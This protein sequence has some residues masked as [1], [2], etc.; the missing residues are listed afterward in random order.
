MRCR[1]SLRHRCSKASHTS[2]ISFH[3]HAASPFRLWHA[4]I[5]TT[6][7]N[8]YLTY[9]TCL[10]IRFALKV[11][12]RKGSTYLGRLIKY[13]PPINTTSTPRLHTRGSTSTSIACLQM[14]ESLLKLP[15][16]LHS[17]HQFQES[18]YITKLLR[19]LK[20][21]YG[22]TARAYRR[23]N[24]FLDVPNSSS[25]PPLLLVSASSPVLSG[26]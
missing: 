13:K 25:C 9:L 4:A 12:A 14:G 3:H 18:V 23:S 11:T 7:C 22:K 19:S 20:M 6:L 24:M 26:T 15:S 2:V 8:T 10:C 17:S 1:Y 21:G 5:S 16:S